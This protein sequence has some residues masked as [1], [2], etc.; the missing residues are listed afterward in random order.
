M[1]ALEPLV[2]ANAKSGLPLGWRQWGRKCCDKALPPLPRSSSLGSGLW[3]LR[4]NRASSGGKSWSDHISDGQKRGGLWGRLCWAVPHITQTRETTDSVLKLQLHGGK[5]GICHSLVLPSWLLLQDP[6]KCSKPDL[7]GQ[8]PI[9][10]PC[11][12]AE[13]LEAWG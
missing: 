6:M 9:P 11:V 12:S 13:S 10:T 7:D 5:E 4:D 2:L 8:H 1:R 3:S